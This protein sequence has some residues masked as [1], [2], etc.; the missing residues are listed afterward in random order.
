MTLK[1]NLGFERVPIAQPCPHETATLPPGGKSTN[2]THPRS[3]T[4][5]HVGSFLHRTSCLQRGAHAQAAASRR[6]LPLCSRLWPG[7]RDKQAGGAGTGG[8]PLPS[9]PPRRAWPSQRASC[10]QALQAMEL[11]RLDPRKTVAAVPSG[12]SKQPFLPPVPWPRPPEQT[13]GG[14][15]PREAQAFPRTRPSPLLPSGLALPV[16]FPGWKE[17]ERVW[18][19]PPAPVHSPPSSTEAPSPEDPAPCLS[20]RLHAQGPG[21]KGRRSRRDGGPS[22]AQGQG[23]G[24]QQPPGGGTGHEYPWLPPKAPPLSLWGCH[25]HLMPLKGGLRAGQGF[26]PDF[27]WGPCACPPG[28]PPQWLLGDFAAQSRWGVPG[29]K[30]PRGTVC[31][32]HARHGASKGASGSS[33]SPR[34]QW[35]QPTAR[36]PTRGLCSPCGPQAPPQGAG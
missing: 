20:Y 19:D 7:Q 23:P 2:S 29:T 28:E 16:C 32:S 6:G 36:Q 8:G 14:Q 24:T 15:H 27:S 11:V 31:P 4:A 10:Q 1:A 5:R 13:D 22:R 33:W 26:A 18:S 17:E 3:H 21:C 35:V 34:S 9:G 30:G 12:P 25:P